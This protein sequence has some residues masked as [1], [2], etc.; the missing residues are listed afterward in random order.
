MAKVKVIYGSTTGSTERAAALIASAF[1]TEAVSIAN[2]EMEDFEADLL[3][4]GSS[5]WGLG[6]LQ[7]DWISG[8]A[9]LDSMDLAGRKVAVFGLG[10]QSGFADTFVD[11]MGILA[12]KAEERGASIIGQTPS[13]GY[14]HSSSAAEKDGHFCGLALDESNEPEKTPERIA[15][16]VEQ[17]KAALV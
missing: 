15:K 2:A 5:T 11:A 4:L 8:I 16:W 9:M 1:E 14:M 3:I 7:D 13:S 17:L 6:E 10:D 12:D